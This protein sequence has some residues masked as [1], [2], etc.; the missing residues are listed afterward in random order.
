M[1]LGRLDN[2][3]SAFGCLLRPATLW[4][5]LG[6]AAVLLF[7]SKPQGALLEP[8]ASHLAWRCLE[9]KTFGVIF[10]WNVWGTAHKTGQSGLE[11]G[12]FP[13]VT[14]KAG[15]LSTGSVCPGHV[16]AHPCGMPFSSFSGGHCVSWCPCCPPTLIV[17]TWTN[18]GVLSLYC[19]WGPSSP[20][21]SNLWKRIM[22]Y[23]YLATYTKIYS[24]SL[25]K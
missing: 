25:N 13:D 15:E 11:A 20:L 14:L 21:S 10:N 22:L 5:T 8:W 24:S 12:S 4:E 9:N 7:C 23:L 2:C 19:T 6:M 3:G 18:S 1:K 16:W 17:C